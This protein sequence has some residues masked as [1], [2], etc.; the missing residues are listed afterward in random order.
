MRY[1]QGTTGVLEHV[2]RVVLGGVALMNLP[3]GITRYGEG[4]VLGQ[5]INYIKFYHN[6]LISLII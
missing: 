2:V 5:L 6:Q 4:V 3:S 1:W